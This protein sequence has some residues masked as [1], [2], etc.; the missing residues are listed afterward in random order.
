M[1]YIIYKDLQSFSFINFQAIFVSSIIF[2]FISEETSY[3][4]CIFY[5]KKE[6]MKLYI[7]GEKSL[8]KF[9]SMGTEFHRF[10]TDSYHL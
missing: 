5:E 6:L 1:Q 4:D 7:I 3:D 8:K 10:F 2:A 9:N